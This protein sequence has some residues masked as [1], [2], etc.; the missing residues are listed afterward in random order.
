MT[1]DNLDGGRVLGAGCPYCHETYPKHKESCVHFKPE[2]APEPVAEES[3]EVVSSHTPA[4]LPLRPAREFQAPAVAEEPRWERLEHMPSNTH[5]WW[6]RGEFEIMALPR[7][8][9]SAIAE[10]ARRE[11]EARARVAEANQDTLA[12]L[13]DADG[14]LDRLTARA[15]A[16]E[17]QV[18][19]LEERLRAL[20]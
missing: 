13:L 12:R 15:E 20:G 3:F 1:N 2:R 18:E 10:E 11:A 14:Q 17:A 19:Q 16:A 8:L 6:Q 7:S 9:E 4:R 5:T